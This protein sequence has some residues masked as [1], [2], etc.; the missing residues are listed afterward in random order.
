MVVILF[1][2]PGL[3]DMVFSQK[4]F[5]DKNHCLVKWDDKGTQVDQSC[6]DPYHS[7]NEWNILVSIFTDITHKMISWK[8]TLQNRTLLPKESN[9][10]FN[11]NPDVS[12]IPCFFNFNRI[13]LTFTFSKA[14]CSDLYDKTLLRHA[15]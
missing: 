1:D 3:Q 14:G 4:G 10:P 5:R 9:N 2:R 6:T 12:K 8:C 11:M 13:E 7:V 15:L